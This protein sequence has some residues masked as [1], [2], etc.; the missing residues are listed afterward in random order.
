MHAPRHGHLLPQD[1]E[2]F[3]LNECA[4]DKV[5][6]AFAAAVRASIEAYRQHLGAGLRSVWLRGSIP[7]GM[8]VAGVSDLD[9]LALVGPGVDLDAPWVQAESARL[10]LAHPEL[11][12]VELWLLSERGLLE[13]PEQ[14][15]R[16]AM[17]ATQA[18]CVDGDALGGRLP[19][20]R[21]GRDTVY[22]CRELR[23]LLAEGLAELRDAEALGDAEARA[24]TLR[25]LGKCLVRAGLEI[26]IPA[27]PVFTRD[28]QP[29]WEVFSRH[30]PAWSE[31][32]RAVMG[33]AVAPAQA[34]AEAAA[35][36]EALGTW[37]VARAAEAWGEILVG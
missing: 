32:M 11:E 36:L 37:L 16:L 7:R 21:P 8:G 9:T 4:H 29:C 30:H 2:G 19:R 6:P 1:A 34:P 27:E 26:C 23:P 33:W 28:L 22:A 15:R 17:L 14:R 12:G 31:E 10:S 20:V 5:D 18:L 25:W 3:L 35:R 13:D 24:A